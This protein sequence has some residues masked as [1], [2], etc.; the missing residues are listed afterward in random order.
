M[1]MDRPYRKA[2]SLDES[3]S[4]LRDGA[5]SQWDPDVVSVFINQV[6]AASDDDHLLAA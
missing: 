5:G 1:T 2:L 3:L 6:L 4:R